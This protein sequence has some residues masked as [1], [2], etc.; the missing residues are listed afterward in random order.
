MA[1]SLSGIRISI[2]VRDENEFKA[3][4]EAAKSEKRTVS[5]YLIRL[6]EL[7]ILEVSM[8]KAQGTTY[9]IGR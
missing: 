8:A 1:Q 4:K 5:N 9:T 6:H 2:Y 7:H 3:L